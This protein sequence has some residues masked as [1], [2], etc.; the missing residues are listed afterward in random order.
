M[1]KLTIEQRLDELE[2]RQALQDA[3]ALA[4]KQ[5]AANT[6]AQ[7]YYLRACASAS[8]ISAADSARRAPAEAAASSRRASEVTRPTGGSQS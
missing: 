5:A 4:Q 2:R 1:S 6:Q 3:D 8:A 7:D